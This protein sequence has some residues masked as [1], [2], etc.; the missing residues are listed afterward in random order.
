MR[1][2]F[3]SLS[4]LFAV[5]VAFLSTASAAFAMRLA[6]PEGSPTTAA[7]A[8][9]HSSGLSLGQVALIAV[10]SVLVLTAAA[11]GARLMRVSR[12]HAS[13]PATN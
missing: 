10:A 2:I 8:A 6:P 9:H 4:S 3:I 13:A 11:L 12:R 7:S 5:T 1:R